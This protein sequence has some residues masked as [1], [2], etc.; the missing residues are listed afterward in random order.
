VPRSPRRTAGA[1]CSMRRLHLD[2]DAPTRGTSLRS[3]PFP[4]YGA[5][6]PRSGAVGGP[7]RARA[8]GRRVNT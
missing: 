2:P 7:D 5:L 3:A 6:P 8:R 4:L 1:N